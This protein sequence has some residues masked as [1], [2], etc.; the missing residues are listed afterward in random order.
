MSWLVQIYLQQRRLWWQA[1]QLS[2]QSVEKELELPQQEASSTNRCQFG[3]FLEMGGKT[4][5]THP[6]SGESRWRST[7]RRCHI[8]HDSVFIANFWY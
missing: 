8:V 4:Y 7:F 1:E 3:S 5:R 2:V 6:R